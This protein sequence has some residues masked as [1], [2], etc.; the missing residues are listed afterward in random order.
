MGKEYVR[1]REG[2]GGAEKRQTESKKQK[3]SA[4]KAENRAHE[5]EIERER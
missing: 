4:K 3:E 5:S 2:R 1:D